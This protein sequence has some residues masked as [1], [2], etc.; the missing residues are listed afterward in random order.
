MPR[1]FVRAYKRWRFGREEH[2]TAHTR[3]WPNQYAFSFMV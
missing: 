2:V 1:V 3:R